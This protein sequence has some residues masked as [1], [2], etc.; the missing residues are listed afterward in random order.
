MATGT[1]RVT[2]KYKWISAGGGAL[3]IG[4]SSVPLNIKTA[5]DP[6]VQLYTTGVLTAGVMRSMEINQKRSITTVTGQDYVFQVTLDSEYKTPG[7]ATAIYGK[8]DYG[9]T[10]SAH[11]MASAIT[12]EMIVPNMSLGRGAL[13]CLELQLGGGA[14]S[15]WAS[16]GPVAFMYFGGWGSGTVTG[17]DTRGYVFDFQGFTEGDG[18]LF[19]DGATPTADG[20]IRFRI[21]T[22][23]RWLLYANDPD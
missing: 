9:S 12:A 18:K 6:L 1:R 13:Y 20:G 19:D 22:S 21:A 5:S 11:G 23:D 10:G 4:T 17:M 2:D 16:A 15:S 14:S 7:S 8:V 3:E